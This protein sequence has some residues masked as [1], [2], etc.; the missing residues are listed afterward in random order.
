MQNKT[1]SRAIRQYY[2]SARTLNRGGFRRR[3]VI[4]RRISLRRDSFVNADQDPRLCDGED[5][6]LVGTRMRPGAECCEPSS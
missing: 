1:Q 4:S 3:S 2:Y 6:D 5:A